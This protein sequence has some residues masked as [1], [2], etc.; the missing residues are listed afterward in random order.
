LDL[1][2]GRQLDRSQTITNPWNA[3]FEDD[4]AVIKVPKKSKEYPRLDTTFPRSDAQCQGLSIWSL[5]LGV[6][7]AVVAL[8][9]RKRT[10]S[11]RRLA[12]W[13]MYKGE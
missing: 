5:G 10:K 9:Y 8:W 7:V 6:P 12:I 4:E 3:F 11:K 13:E 2:T 1:K